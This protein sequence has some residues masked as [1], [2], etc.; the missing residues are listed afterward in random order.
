MY[1]VLINES[2]KQMPTDTRVYGPFRSEEAAQAFADKVEARANKITRERDAD[3]WFHAWVVW[4]EKP[5]LRVAYEAVDDI[6][7]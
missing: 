1:V 4:I 7:D 5:R 6:I 2:N 3:V